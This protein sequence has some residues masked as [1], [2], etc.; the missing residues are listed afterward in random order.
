[1]KKQRGRPEEIATL[2]DVDIYGMI[3]F[4]RILTKY[5]LRMHTGFKWLRKGLIVGCSK[6]GNAYVPYMSDMC[7]Q[8]SLFD[9]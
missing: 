4:K 9:L 6:H 7:M 5:N 8:T 3:L 2:G 1:V